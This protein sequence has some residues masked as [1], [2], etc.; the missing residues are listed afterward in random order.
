MIAYTAQSGQTSVVSRHWT[1]YV[2]Y[3]AAD[4]L[5]DEDLTKLSEHDLL[6]RARTDLLR[7]LIE[8][9]LSIT[10]KATLVSLYDVLDRR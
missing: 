4:E 3:M 2:R 10:D 1:A 9:E 8:Y 5:V 6:Y 7:H